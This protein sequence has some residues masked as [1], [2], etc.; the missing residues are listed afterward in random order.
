MGVKPD[1]WRIQTKDDL[2]QGAEK[3][4][5]EKENPA[6]WGASRFTLLAIYQSELSNHK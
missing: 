2:E 3:I 6:D 4:I 1:V 5:V